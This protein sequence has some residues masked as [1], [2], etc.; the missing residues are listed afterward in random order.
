M[1]HRHRSLR[2]TERPASIRVGEH[3][4]RHRGRPGG[5]RERSWTDATCAQEHRATL[6]PGRGRREEPRSDRGVPCCIHGHPLPTLTRPGPTAP[7]GLPAEREKDSRG[8]RTADGSGCLSL[9]TG[10][11]SQRLPFLLRMELNSIIMKNRPKSKALHLL[12]FHT[13]GFLAFRRQRCNL[14]FTMRS[15]EVYIQGD[16]GDEIPPLLI[17]ADEAPCYAVWACI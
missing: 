7:R 15:E 4:G 14:T 13:T 3:R 1:L 8:D 10:V 2:H 6:L 17:R 16:K 9:A 12:H 11:R 5:R